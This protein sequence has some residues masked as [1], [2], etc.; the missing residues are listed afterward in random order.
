MYYGNCMMGLCLCGSSDDDDEDSFHGNGNVQ[1]VLTLEAWEETL[2]YQGKIIIACF[3]AAWC[4]PCK[5]IAPFYGDIS[6]FGI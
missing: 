3:K 6:L 1:H 5:I 4:G 2:N